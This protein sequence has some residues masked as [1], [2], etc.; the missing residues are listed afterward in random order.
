MSDKNPKPLADKP[1]G[2]GEETFL[3]RWSRLKTSGEAPE[4]RG[5]PPAA[6][7]SVNEAGA[8]GMADEPPALT[9]A[10]MPDLDTINEHSDVSGFLSA[11]VS[12]GLRRKALRKLFTGA[13]FNIRDGLDDYDDDFR[14]FPALG[15]IVTAD[16]RHHLERKIEAAKAM[17][18]K[19]LANMG[20]GASDAP[21]VTDGAG[22]ET[23]GA[24]ESGPAAADGEDARRDNDNDEESRN[25]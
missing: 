15:G 16:M 13:K 11:G 7:D 12:E 17:A 19:K 20:G 14:S 10:D 6:G 4:A 8:S 9:D 5:E 2:D 24:G 1:G 3:E 18:E 22:E 21:G 25:A 23:A